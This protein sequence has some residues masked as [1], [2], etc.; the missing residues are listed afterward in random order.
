M[1]I[2]L[3]AIMAISGCVNNTPT[4]N[5]PYILVGSS[6]CLDQNSNNICDSDESSNTAGSNTVAS[7]GDNTCASGET[8]ENCCKDCGCPAGESCGTS[9]PDI[10]SYWENTCVVNAKVRTT[11]VGCDRVDTQTIKVH[12]VLQNEGNPVTIDYIQP[13]IWG[14]DE[15]GCDPHWNAYQHNNAIIGRAIR[16]EEG[17]TYSGEGTMTLGTNIIPK[18]W[19]IKIEG[20]VR[21]VDNMVF[22]TIEND[23]DE[24]VNNPC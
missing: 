10:A 21:K 22:D 1:P 17:D 16:L 2:M 24:S 11:Y 4:C 7:C 13:V 9:N 23:K 5:S 18:S 19:Y 15:A 3:L 14:C 8:Q 12:Y 20:S 6:C